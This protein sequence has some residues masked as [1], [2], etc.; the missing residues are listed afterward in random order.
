MLWGNLH[1][2]SI[3]FGQST[4]IGYIRGDGRGGATVCFRSK[5]LFAPQNLRTSVID[6]REEYAGSEIFVKSW[7]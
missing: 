1:G 2:L 5:G 3:V 6:G 7:D 4:K